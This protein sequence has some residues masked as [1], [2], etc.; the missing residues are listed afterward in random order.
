MAGRDVGH[1]GATVEDRM[2]LIE[3]D[4]MIGHD[5]TPI[6][7]HIIHLYLPVILG[8]QRHPAYFF[9]NILVTQTF[10]AVKFSDKIRVVP[11]KPHHAL[12]P[13]VYVSEIKGEHVPLYDALRV[14]F[15]HEYVCGVVGGR[16]RCH[17]D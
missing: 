1:G 9:C 7:S 8:C 6:H 5:P 2:C 13:F 10:E 12:L 14:Q 16:V 11:S 17:T 15:V 4:L 3:L